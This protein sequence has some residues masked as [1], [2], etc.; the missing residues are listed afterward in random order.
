MI[1]TITPIWS[2][3]AIAF[4]R[5]EA[6]RCAPRETG[7]V[8]LGRA[9]GKEVRIEYAIGP[10]PQARHRDYTFWPD[11]DWQSA[12]ID[13]LWGGDQTIEYL[14]DWHT[15]PMHPPDMS[16]MD[17]DVLRKIA[18]APEARQPKPI[19]AIFPWEMSIPTVYRWNS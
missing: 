8:L 18:Q 6:I 4:C 16:F 2:D 14:G 12:E 3:A 10:G 17:M 15:H 13:R 9:N 19:M 1:T 7:G 5:S 11:T